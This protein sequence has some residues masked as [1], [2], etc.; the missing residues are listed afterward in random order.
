[1]KL[2][3]I[4]SSLSLIVLL[5]PLTP[6]PQA[7]QPPPELYTGTVLCLPDVY[8]QP[9]S[10]CLPAGPS[11]YL[12]RMAAFG[13]TFP[14]QPLPAKSPDEE[15]S[16][17]PYNYARVTSGNTPLFTSL[18]AAMDGKPVG[19][20]IEVGFNYVS[21]SRQAVVDGRAFYFLSTQEWIRG[22]DI[23][24]ITPSSFQGL[25]FY[26]TPD[27]PFAWVLYPIH[28][29]HSPGYTKRDYTTHFLNRYDVVQIYAT[30]KIEGLDWYMVG[31]DEWVEQRLV[32]R[33][34]PDS[35]PPYGVY[36]RRWIEINLFEQTITVY[37]N[38]QLIFATLASTGLPGWWT[39]PG[40]FRI[41]KKLVTTSMQGAFEADR[42]DFY[43]LQDVPW[44]MY[45]DQER[46]LHGAYW[47]DGFGYPR[48]HGCVNLS[49]GDSHWLYN[50][51]HAGDW[52]YVWDPSGKTPTDPDLF[53]PGSP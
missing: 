44:S 26:R 23:T 48:S 34:I 24:R 13:I 14:M 15:L 51:A 28:T 22:G 39:R 7:E 50:W 47:H 49:P 29:K 2:P 17:V 40:L 19:R 5:T 6:L 30:E 8:L 43:Y 37:E 27:R 11:T 42:S 32:A 46:A 45:F 31:P 21:Y 25:L 41:Y 3:P 10:D 38:N 20:R 12:A 53:P 1:M 18:D 35:T 16:Y 36:N 33:V 4:F 52:V 9:P